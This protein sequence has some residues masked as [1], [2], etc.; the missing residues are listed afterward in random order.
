MKT[1]R[2]DPCPCGSGKKY[3]QCCLSPASAVSEEFSESLTGQDLHSI[4]EVQALA[5]GFMQQRN[6]QPLDDFQ[7]LSSE[8]VHR[9]LHFPFD[10]PEFFSFPEMLS[11]EPETP[12]LQLIQ[13]ISATIDE[14][15][16]KA[17]A[18]GNLPLKLC[19]Q[20]KVDYLQY[21]PAGD[22]L[23]RTNI[24][25]EVDFENLHMARV[26]MELSGLIRKTRGRFFL[27][28]KYQQ[29][30][31]KTGF[32]GIYPLLLKTY[33]LKFNWAYRD[34]YEDIPFIQQSFLFSLYLLKLHGDDW[35]PFFIYEDYFLQ[36]FPMVISEAE[37]GPYRGA[38]DVVRSCY[39][40]RTLDRFL[41]FMGLAS[42]ETIPN[43]KPFPRNYRI[44]K[45]PL[46]ESVVHFTA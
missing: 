43:D 46:L 36:A 17:T 20:A 29:L 38:E 28:R 34:G 42:I 12:I 25:S 3:K 4:E 19:K 27:T 45:L 44:R 5:E 33:C 31:G 18:K 37:S 6:Q 21:L 41:H 23:H 8:H 30:T 14:K 35:K 9:M 16:L 13:A 7:G 32:A 22:Y 1:G 26:L 24:S 40:I 15:G 10:T 39:S 11:S 2:N